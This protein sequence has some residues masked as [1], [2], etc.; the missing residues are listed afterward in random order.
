MENFA[1]TISVTI[2][3][4]GETSVVTTSALLPIM[5]PIGAELTIE[6]GG[7][8]LPLIVE[9][10][11]YNLTHGALYISTSLPSVV[12]CL[13]DGDS[14]EISPSEM[15]EMLIAA[16]FQV[17]DVWRDDDPQPEPHKAKRRRSRARSPPR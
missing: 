11:T 14:Q 12:R 4:R 3:A 8:P 15:M 16:G 17:T 6:C 5:P 7:D 13:P 9:R 10:V 1:A 2:R